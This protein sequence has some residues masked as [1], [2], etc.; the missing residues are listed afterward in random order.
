[1]SGVVQHLWAGAASA[2]SPALRCWLRLRLRRGK[3]IA[4]RLP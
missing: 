4:G 1:M 3:E 2:A